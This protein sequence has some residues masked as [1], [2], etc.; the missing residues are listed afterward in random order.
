MSYPSIEHLQQ[1]LEYQL[2]QH[3]EGFSEH[4][5][6]QLLRDKDASLLPH[7][8]LRDPLA[9]FQIHF[10]LFHALYLL[11]DRLWQQQRGHLEISALSI[12]LAPWRAGQAGIERAD[13]LREYY[14]NLDNLEDTG[15]AEVEELLDRFWLR[16]GGKEERRAALAELGLRDPVDDATIK[17]AWR[18]LAMQHHPDR[19]GDKDKLQL[20][21]AAMEWLKKN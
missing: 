14:L 18:R 17:R 2:R 9:L 11:R 10:I 4:A 16:L 6:I 21:N 1:E 3:A 5:L 13:P 19:G 15:I 7:G 8:R 20:V 12:R